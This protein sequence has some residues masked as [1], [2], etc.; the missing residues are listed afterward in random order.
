MAKAEIKFGELGGGIS[1]NPTIL[2]D[3][4]ASANTSKTVTAGKHYAITA[5]RRS[6][7]NSNR[8]AYWVIDDTDTPLLSGGSE[9]GVYITLTKSGTSLSFTITSS[10]KFEIIIIQ[11]D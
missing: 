3:F 10:R 6:D 1:L 5:T 7:D 11:L 4:I 9:N 2:D 8:D